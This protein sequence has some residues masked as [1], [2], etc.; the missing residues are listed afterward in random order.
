M[1]LVEWQITLVISLSSVGVGSLLT[2]LV[3]EVRELRKRNRIN[4]KIKKAL[5]K[6][7]EISSQTLNGI[8]EEKQPEKGKLTRISRDSQYYRLLPLYVDFYKKLSLE[9]LI[10]V[11]KDQKLEFVRDA[12]MIIDIFNSAS[13]PITSRA[14]LNSAKELSIQKL[15]PWGL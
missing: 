1:Q 14:C 4:K 2:F 3:L 13:L 15:V 12:Y 5:I 9:K 6:E 11:V 10:E 7:L 8:I